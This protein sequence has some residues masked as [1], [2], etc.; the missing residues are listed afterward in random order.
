M[1]LLNF[2]VFTSVRL[3]VSAIPVEVPNGILRN[4][5]IVHRD[6]QCS[7]PYLPIILTTVLSLELRHFCCAE[8]HYVFHSQAVCEP[9]V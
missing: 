7:L 5:S 9:K 1:L 3:F 6:K 8:N 2:E 4:F